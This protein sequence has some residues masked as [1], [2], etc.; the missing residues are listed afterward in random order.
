MLAALLVTAPLAVSAAPALEQLPRLA[1]DPLPETAEPPRQSDALLRWAAR[2]IAG[3]TLLHVDTQPRV[4]P[5][6][7]GRAAALAQVRQAL[8]AGPVAAAALMPL[9]EPP[10][11]D[12][13]FVRAA[14]ALGIA[15]EVFWIVPFDYFRHPDPAGHLLADMRDAGFRPEELGSFT[16]A[17]GCL[18]GTVESAPFAI[19]GLEQLP[20]IA[21]PVLGSLHTDFPLAAA[22][23]LVTHPLNEASRL[24]KS[25]A[26]AGYRTLD[27]VVHATPVPEEGTF[28][29]PDLRWI[30]EALAQALRE[31]SL[32]GRPE[33]VRRW[34][35]LHAVTA[36]LSLGQFAEAYHEVL[37]PLTAHDDDPALRLLAARALAGLGR[38]DE[39]EQHAVRACRLHTAY[40][41]GLPWIG[42]HL[43]IAGDPDGGER[44]YAL[45]SRLVP[46]MSFGQ[47]SRGVELARAGRNDQAL[48]VLRSRSDAGEAYPAGF[49]AGA[50]ALEKGDRQE[51]RRLFDLAAG[52]LRAEHRVTE[53]DPL[54]VE[55]VRVALRFYREGGLPARADAIEA[56]LIL[57]PAAEAPLQ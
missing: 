41:L 3:A 27:A 47:V 29:T 21:A 38:L 25:L 43:S 1:V 12:R 15:R 35:V 34:T 6:P 19:C 46:G 55:A 5:L 33:G 11:L 26:G 13:S 39:A 44:F 18:R 23:T 32:L 57:A 10:S 52:T 17:D 9:L 40:C 20:K 48:E 45:G 51:A 36:L 7:A 8:A 22:G 31:P 53:G 37:P 56:A 14:V 28:V 16:L 42:Q 54:I 24:L 2:G 50:L 49:V 4:E 30:G